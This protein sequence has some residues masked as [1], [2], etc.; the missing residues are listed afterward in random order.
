MNRRAFVVG[1][2]LVALARRARADDVDPAV[3]ARWIAGMASSIGATPEWQAYATGEDERW[4]RTREMR[5]AP[6][7]EFAGREVAPLL[8]REPIVFYPFAGPDAMHAI[9]LLGSAR[10]YLLVGLEPP[11][12]LPD[13]QAT[14]RGF[15]ARLAGAMADVHRL[16]FFRTQEMAS[17]Y[18]ADGVAATLL[19]TITRMNGAVSSVRTTATTV[20][21]AWNGRR[22]DYVQA[23]LSNSGLQQSPQLIAQ[24]EAL[25]AHTTLIKAAMYL[26]AEPRFSTLRNL[27]LAKAS[28]VVQD[29][30]GISY[31]HF[32]ASWT[33]RLF[34]RYEAP[35]HPF[36]ERF[37]PEL[38]VAYDRRN[39]PAL[40]FGIGYGVEAKR[41]NLLIASKVRG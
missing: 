11:G 36:E 9:A 10:R 37:Q 39:P 7:Q 30:T 20:T 23:D 3:R 27:I 5:L 21:I 35:R 2:L 17:D 26:L 28:L 40:G 4:M 6:M 19:A 8:G 14:P 25:G 18:K 38:R 13:P 1:P 12:T 24:I 41:S 29:D 31:R 16:S 34:G 33:T 15:F 22:L 32:D